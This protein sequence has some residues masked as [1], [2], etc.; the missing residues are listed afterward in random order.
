MSLSASVDTANANG[1]EDF[2]RPISMQT[3]DTRL[4]RNVIAI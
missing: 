2:L 3:W 1:C 4:D